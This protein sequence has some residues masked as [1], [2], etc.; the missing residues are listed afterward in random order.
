MSA[1]AIALSCA[2][3]VAACAL[4]T[5]E[6]ADV[7]QSLVARDPDTEPLPPAARTRIPDPRNPV[8]VSAAPSVASSAAP[9]AATESPPT[10]TASASVAAQAAPKPKPA[11]TATAPDCGSK[12]NPCPMQKYMRGTMTSA[13]TPEALEAAFKR[14][15]ALSPNA[16][17][18]WTA[19]A[20]KGAEL[21][22]AGDVASAKKQCKAC[23][24]A[25]KEPY[26]AQYRARKL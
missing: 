26:K 16:G 7:P 3:M 22:K 21:V 14:V 10:P 23:H 8:T 9:S 1:R 2:G 13:S 17:W 6:P 11:A 19:M 25:Y 15:A 24:D 18:Q 4:G 5:G 20:A 12:D